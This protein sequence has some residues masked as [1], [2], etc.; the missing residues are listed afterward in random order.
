MSQVLHFP[1]HALAFLSLLPHEPVSPH[2]GVHD[3]NPH[4]E[5]GRFSRSKRAPRASPSCPPTSREQKDRSLL[6][7]CTAIR[8]SENGRHGLMTTS[9]CHCV[10]EDVERE[11]RVVPLRM[12]ARSR[13]MG[14]GAC[15]HI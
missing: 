8:E 5:C 11:G 1:V 12:S 2:Q 3:S 10:G 13:L 9:V 15:G 14:N 7:E 6:S 4:R